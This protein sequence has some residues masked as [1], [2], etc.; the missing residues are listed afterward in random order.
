AGWGADS[1]PG[2]GT[3]SRWDATPG[4]AGQ[5]APTPRRNR[6]DDATPAQQGGA[7][8]AWGGGETPAV[9]SDA[10]DG[11]K[12]RS[13]W[14]ETPAALAGGAT[15]SMGLT[16]GFFSG[17]TPAGAMGME[18]PATAAMHKLAQQ[19]PMTPEQYQ[20]ARTQREMFERNKPLTDEE[21]DALLPGEKD[22][23]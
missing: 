11:K 12:A 20:E 8:P 9:T 22:G 4:A 17:A 2:L 3:S 21:L 16:P 10:G 5:A 23:Y 15:P 14:D 6:W 19:I 18:T 7:T 13:R 1:T